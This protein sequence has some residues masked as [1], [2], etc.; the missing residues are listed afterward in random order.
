MLPWVH[1]AAAADHP[2]LILVLVET[3]AAAVLEVKKKKHSR[4]A[5]D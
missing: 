4:V 5:A 3:A 1:E 2:K